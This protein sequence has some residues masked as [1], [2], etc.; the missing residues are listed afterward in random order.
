MNTRNLK[1][2]LQYDGTEFHGFQ[3]QPNAVT[4][5]GCVENAL[6]SVTSEDIKINGCSRTDAGV[7]AFR[8]VCSFLTSFPIPA[9]RLPI[10]LNHKLPKSI[11]AI[12][13][14]EVDNNFHARFD[15]TS[16]TYRYSINTDSEFNVFM[17][18]YEWQ[19][20][21]KLDTDK[22]R[23]AAEHIIGEHDFNCFKSSGGSNCSTIRTVYSLEITDKGE[24]VEVYINA[25]GYLYN[26]VRI[27]TGTLV[28]V[29]LGIFEPSYIKD[30]IDSKS[31]EKAGPTAPP[32]GLYLYEVQY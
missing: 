8:Y 4:V 32:Q 28:N 21:K 19:L 3:I 29:G 12:E 1:L 7:H 20:G 30:I 26:M 13:C 14:E 6:S 10:V 17:R 24:H 27:I 15:T 22:M 25:N 2:T 11:R 18:N 31:R 16:K 9:E 5:Q 23:E